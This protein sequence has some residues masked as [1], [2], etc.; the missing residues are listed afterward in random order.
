M[1]RDKNSIDTFIKHNTTQQNNHNK[2]VI[3]DESITRVPLREV[4]VN[5]EKRNNSQSMFKNNT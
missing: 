3:D 4:D 5:Q 1:V 2:L